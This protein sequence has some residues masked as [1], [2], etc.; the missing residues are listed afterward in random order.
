MFA[1]SFFLAFPFKQISFVLEK[2]CNPGKVGNRDYTLSKG[3][4]GIRMQ[5]HKTPYFFGVSDKPSQSTYENMLEAVT[6]VKMKQQMT[7]NNN[8]KL[9]FIIMK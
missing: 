5:I 1:F 4:K 8:I 6:L 7:N 9:N 3:N 2:V